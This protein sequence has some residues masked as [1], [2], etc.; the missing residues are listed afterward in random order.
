MYYDKNMPTTIPVRIVNTNKA[1]NILKFKAKI[2][3][4][5]GI[6]NVIKWYKKSEKLF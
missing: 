2:S 5:E 1:K 4:E 6:K 3:L